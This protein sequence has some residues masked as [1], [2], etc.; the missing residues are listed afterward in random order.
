LTY[1]EIAAALNK[2]KLATRTGA[3]WR[4]GTVRRIVRRTTVSS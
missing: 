4:A 1:A 2:E 3:P